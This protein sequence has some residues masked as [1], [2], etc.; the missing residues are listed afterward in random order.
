M[1]VLLC[2]LLDGT[3]RP[4]GLVTIFGLR[5]DQPY[6]L[7]SVD[8]RLAGPSITRVSLGSTQGPSIELKE[9]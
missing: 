2:C 5:A 3:F 6:P 7:I 4:L 9:Y 8:V 1:A